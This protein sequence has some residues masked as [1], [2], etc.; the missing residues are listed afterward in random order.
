MHFGL[1]KCSLPMHFSLQ[2]DPSAPGSAGGS[3]EEADAV[4]VDESTGPKA[5]GQGSVEHAGQPDP[6]S[7]ESTGP[8]NQ[9]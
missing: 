6:N 9:I 4:K 2:N 5:A 8:T 1:V 7:P 3:P